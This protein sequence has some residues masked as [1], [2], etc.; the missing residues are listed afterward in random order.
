MN[1]DCIFSILQRKYQCYLRSVTARRE[2][3]TTLEIN[4]NK[5]VQLVHHAL[6]TIQ[7]QNAKELSSYD[8]VKYRLDRNLLLWSTLIHFQI[9][10]Y[11]KIIMN[12]SN[13][14]IENNQ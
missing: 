5:V 10:K 14:R 8:M 7:S 6:E 2:R 12:K 1:R 13:I 3:H 4:G 11:F 9:F